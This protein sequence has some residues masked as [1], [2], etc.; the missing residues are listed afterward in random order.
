MVPASAERALSLTP[1]VEELT[2]VT[3]PSEPT[4]LEPEEAVQP[5]ESAMVPRRRTPASPDFNFSWAD[6]SKPPPLE[7]TDQPMSIPQGSQLDLTPL[8]SLEWTLSH[9]PVTG[10]VQFQYQ[11]LVVAQTF[12]KLTC[13]NP[14]N[15]LTP[16]HGLR[17][18]EQMQCSLP[19]QQE[20]TL[21]LNS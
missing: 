13:L 17:S 3:P 20:T 7:D 14:Q 8:V 5:K 6:R 2:S 19:D 9:Y 10:E 21:L 16:L 11:T 4:T 15:N 12:L 1:R 18:S